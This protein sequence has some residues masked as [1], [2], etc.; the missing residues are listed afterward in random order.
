MPAQFNTAVTT[1]TPPAKEV[2][3]KT[4]LVARTDTT[5]FDAFSLPKGAV[6]GGVYVMAQTASDASVSASIS[7]GSNPGTTNECLAAYDVKS[8]T[9]GKGYNAAG[10]YAGTS[11]GNAVTTGSAG[12]T[13]DTLIKAKY[14]ESGTA[15]TTG[16]PWLVKVEY[17][18]PQQGVY[19]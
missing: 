2:L 9:L 11:V 3:V 10:T 6:L 1:L 17:Y 8:A 18:I 4:A 16:G 7:L 19:W 5:A 14:V 12:L 15:S 13:S